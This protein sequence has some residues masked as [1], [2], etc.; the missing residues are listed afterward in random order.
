MQRVP[1]LGIPSLFRDVRSWRRAAHEGPRRHPRCTLQPRTHAERPTVDRRPRA[2]AR[3][4]R[5][6]ALATPLALPCIGT[7]GGTSHC[8]CGKHRTSRDCIR[9]RRNAHSDAYAPRGRARRSGLVMAHR[10]RPRPRRL[11]LK[12]M[13]VEAQRSTPRTRPLVGTPVPAVTTTCSSPATWLTDVP[14][15]R[16]TASAIP[17]MPCR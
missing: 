9:V 14:R 13:N 15:T 12:E 1:I 4:D 6:K 8:I 10:G 3:S 11:S 2:I 17:F 16:R 7:R 5:S